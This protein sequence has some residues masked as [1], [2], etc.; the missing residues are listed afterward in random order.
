AD[1]GRPSA[2][3]AAGAGGGRGLTR[4]DAL[5]GRPF[6]AIMLPAVAGR[7][8]LGERAPGAPGPMR[9]KRRDTPLSR[10]RGEGLP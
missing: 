4:R 3:M 5:A 1:E 2:K 8:P 9:D 7:V 6:G 10:V